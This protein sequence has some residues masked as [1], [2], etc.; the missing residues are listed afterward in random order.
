M[1]SSRHMLYTATLLV[2]FVFFGTDSR[3]QSTCECADDWD[4]TALIPP[5]LF[6]FGAWVKIYA[7]SEYQGKVIL[8]GDFKCVGGPWSSGACTGATAQEV[9]NIVAWDPGEGTWEALGT[10]VWNDGD[11]QT[12]GE[13]KALAVFDGKLYVGGNIKCAGGTLAAPGTCCPDGDDVLNGRCCPGGGSFDGGDNS[14]CCVGGTYN[15]GNC[16]VGGQVV[17]ETPTTEPIAYGGLAVWDGSTST[18][19]VPQDTSGPVVYNNGEVRALAVHDSSLFAGGTF[20]KYG[21]EGFYGLIDKIAGPGAEPGDL[22][23]LEVNALVSDQEHLYVGGD[24]SGYA[25]TPDACADPSSAQTENVRSLVRWSE[26]GGYEEVG[27]GVYVGESPFDESGCLCFECLCA[28][29]GEGVVNALLIDGADLYVGGYFRRVG[30]K[31]ANGVAKYNLTSGSWTTMHSGLAEDQ[32][33]HSL[34][35]FDEG[36]GKRSALYAG[37]SIVPYIFRYDGSRWSGVGTGTDREVYSLSTISTLGD[38]P[39][40]R[41]VVGGEF[42]TANGSAATGVATIGYTTDVDTDGDGLLDNCEPA[43]CENVPNLVNTVPVDCNGNGRYESLLGERVGQRLDCDGDGYFDACDR[44][45][46]GP[47]DLDRDDDGTPDSCDE[48]YN[49]VHTVATD[50]NGDGDTLDPPEQV[51]ERCPCPP[52]NPDYLRITEVRD[53]AGNVLETYDYSVSDEITHYT[54]TPAAF[55]LKTIYTLNADGNPTE[56]S[57]FLPGSAQPDRQS[58]VIYD[59]DRPTMAIGKIGDVS[60]CGCSGGGQFVYRDPRSRVL[61]KETAEVDANNVP[62][63]SVIEDL[64]Y[65]DNYVWVVDPDPGPGDPPGAFVLTDA[66]GD[67]HVDDRL[68]ERRRIDESGLQLITVEK[69]AYCNRTDGA[70]TELVCKRASDDDPV[71]DVMVNDY[72]SR[73]R[74]TGSRTYTTRQSDCPSDVGVDCS[75]AG[76]CADVCTFADGPASYRATT[77]AYDETPANGWPLTSETVTSTLPSGVKEVSTWRKYDNGQG[78]YLERRSYRE[79]DGETCTGNCVDERIETLIFDSALGDYKLQ[80]VG[81]PDGAVS[82]YAYYGSPDSGRVKTVLRSGDSVLSGTQ[83]SITRT[84]YDAA[85]RVSAEIRTSPN[86]AGQDGNSCATVGAG[87]CV[88]TTFEYDEYG[89]VTTEVTGDDGLPGYSAGERVVKYGYDGW[90]EQVFRAQLLDSEAPT[91]TYAI[92]GSIYNALGQLKDEYTAEYSGDLAAFEP[93]LETAPIPVLE[94]RSF[95]YHSVSGKIELEQVALSD[96]VPFSFDA[97]VL[98][99][100]T[101]YSYD[102]TGSWLLSRQDPGEATATTYDYDPAGRTV[103]SVSPLGVVKETVFDPGGRISESILRDEP[104]TMRVSTK[105][106]YDA[107]GRVDYVQ[108]PSGGNVT[109]FT[110]NTYDEY[111][112]LNT[113]Q[114]CDTSDCSGSIVITEN[115]EYTGSSRIKRRYISGVSDTVTDYDEFG[116]AYRVRRRA[117]EGTDEDDDSSFNAD[118]VTLKE[119]TASGQVAKIAEKVESD[120][121]SIVEGTDVVTEFLYDDL[122]QTLESTRVNYGNVNGTPQLIYE[123]AKQRYDD[124]GRMDERTVCLDH[125][126]CTGSNALVTTQEFDALGRVTKSIDPEGH[127]ATQDYDSRGHRTK[128]VSYEEPNVGERDGEGG[129]ALAQSRWSYDAAGRLGQSAQMADAASVSTPDPAVDRVVNYVYEQ[130]H[131]TEGWQ[132]VKST[133]NMNSAT[134][135]ENTTVYD[136]LGRVKQTI[137]AL[138]NTVTNFYLS[139]TNVVDYRETR[140]GLEATHGIVKVDLDYDNLGRVTQQVQVEQQPSNPSLETIATVYDGYDG[141]DRPT[142]VFRN[143]LGDGLILD[144]TD[145]TFDLL[146][147][148]TK[149]VEAKA[150]PNERSTVSRYDRLGRLRELEAD[151]SDA[152]G[153]DTKQVTAYAYDLAGRRTKIV[154]PDSSGSADALD[155]EYDPA[156][157]LT[158]RSDQ[159]GVETDFTYDKRGLLIQQHMDDDPGLAGSLDYLFDYDGI[160]RMKTAHRFGLKFSAIYAESEFTYNDLSDIVSDKQTVGSVTKDF[161]K[162]YDQAGNRIGTDCPLVGSSEVACIGTAYDALNRAT[163][164]ERDQAPFIQYSYTNGGA[165]LQMAAVSIE[166]SVAGNSFERSVLYNNQRQIAEIKNTKS[167]GGQ[168]STVAR[169]EFTEYDGLGKPRSMVVT[170]LPQY[171][172]TMSYDYDDLQR[173]HSAEYDGDPSKTETFTMDSLGNRTEYDNTYSTAMSITYGAN[174]KANEYNNI[175][176]QPLSYDAAGN[177]I[178]NEHGFEFEY[179]YGSHLYTV[180]GGVV[181]SYGYDALGRRVYSQQDGEVTY[182]FYDGQRVFAETDS[183]GGLRRYYVDG[184]A[185]VDEHMAVVEQDGQGQQD[186]YYVLGPL[187]SVVGIVEPNGNLVEATR[188]DAYGLPHTTRRPGNPL[189]SEAGSRYIDVVPADGEDPIALMITGYDPT[190]LTCIQLFVQDDDPATGS[191][192]EFGT[193]GGTPVYMTPAE[194]VAASGDGTIHVRGNLILSAFC[195]EPCGGPATPAQYIVQ[196]VTSGG[197]GEMYSDESVMAE[198][199]RRGDTDDDGH[200]DFNDVSRVVDAFQG[201]YGIGT[202]PLTFQM[203]DLVGASNACE[204]QGPPN[205]VDFT[206]TSEAVAAFLGEPDPCASDREYCDGLPPSAAPAGGTV[207]ARPGNEYYYTGRRLDANVYDTDGSV[208]G[209]VGTPLL[210]LAHHRARAYDLLHGR[211]LQRDPAK[212]VDGM[213]LYEYVRSAPIFHLDPSGLAWNICEKIAQIARSSWEASGHMILGDVASE[214]GGVFGLEYAATVDAYERAYWTRS[215]KNVYRCKIGECCVRIFGTSGARM[216]I[217]ESHR[218][219]TSGVGAEGLILAPFMDVGGAIG[220]TVS[221]VL[222][223]T[224]GKLFDALASKVTDQITNGL[225]VPIW[226]RWATSERNFAPEPDDA[227][228]GA[229]L[230]A[231][232]LPSVSDLKLGKQ[233]CKGNTFDPYVLDLILNSAELLPDD[234]LP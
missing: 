156:G 84:L 144:E 160:G 7:V 39:L 2:A 88:A 104:E 198:T 1:H 50:C 202:P 106:F 3:A 189:V 193:V 118:H 56:I 201:N 107:A 112:R 87:G 154:Y 83:K 15:N 8:G 61:R 176:G 155:F 79:K 172:Q 71:W 113:A 70:F 192:N 101:V 228:M 179:D 182:Y 24:F 129:T 175:D 117:T 187:Y 77:Y 139:G 73:G 13:V 31:L 127:Y 44:C 231:S 206:D 110:R 47:D 188:Y 145:Y 68:V 162:K 207:A 170:G 212:Y 30:M 221:H 190:E 16:E 43:G 60:G 91:P 146:G 18:W 119:F 55:A 99:A 143:V 75:N 183:A 26:S 29:C 12:D 209:T 181:G 22:I 109:P 225:T 78:Q 66:N 120:P 153:G 17:P 215:Y 222:Q 74:V 103:K 164:I 213:N 35:L 25:S 98:T 62:N 4:A 224:E 135:L 196:A 171:T 163:T 158:W 151:D 100:D 232:E 23:G 65:V 138:G 173:L 96:T 14:E 161:K 72:D 93:D 27:D 111:D 102:P 9:N 116:R 37:G 211:W 210:V 85:G 19:S 167:I 227:D 54:G 159:R 97:S 41:L 184:A 114:R 28:E 230:I 21:P 186:F 233:N 67:G 115:Y 45:P 169:F 81:E 131:A 90:N 216:R 141:A 92:G 204:P 95:G 220:A 57:E 203:A 6:P 157:R 130:P 165:G 200:C 76:D 38:P 125:L 124:A 195:D 49:P 63:G 150:T 149:V 105:T 46:V 174:N 229:D 33:I 180:D 166:S 168:N 219:R 48:C 58:R 217:T 177:L 108:R 11:G 223:G 136:K 59:P 142:K 69:H 123:L 185:Y 137:D 36:C 197:A 140:D 5:D 132:D 205:G 199:W 20:A 148:R 191:Y 121:S 218:N 40:P 226:T 80:S 128:S 208:T 53:G 126:D 89:R 214:Q 94:K 32:Y 234:E 64:V 122:G 42:V 52:R 152:P 10:G 134:P 147:R 82:T 194:W 34:A 133:Y 86:G 51:G 178:S